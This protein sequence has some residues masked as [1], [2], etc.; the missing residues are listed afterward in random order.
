MKHALLFTGLLFALLFGQ[1]SAASC[2]ML[3]IETYDVD[4]WQG[5][6]K[7]V[8]FALHNHGNER[9][10]IDRVNAFDFESGLTVEEHS[11]DD[12]ALA[13]GEAMLR[14]EI[15][16][17]NNAEEGERDARIEVK[18]H[19]LGGKKCGFSDAG[20]GFSVSVLE[21][22]V[23]RLSPKC[24]GFALYT[25]KEK[26]IDGFGVIEFIAD[27]KTNYPAVITLEAPKMGLG[28]E[29]F[30]SKSGEEKIFSVEVQSAVEEAEL[31]YNVSLSSCGIPGEKTIV[32]SR[33]YPDP[34]PQP[35]PVPAEKE[36]EVNVSVKED[37][38]GFVAEVSIYNPGNAFVNGVLEASVASDWGVSG[39][40]YIEIEPYTE[41]IA[42]IRLV[43]P[44]GF[45]GKET[46]QIAFSWN[47]KTELKNFSMEAEEEK[48]LDVVGAAFAVLGSGAVLI[49]LLV[50][51]AILV[52]LL[53]SGPSRQ[54]FEP[55]LEKQAVK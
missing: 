22:P 55:W 31:V 2:G 45:S 32:Y 46:G 16:A 18:G 49:G 15:K 1:A 54:E 28:Q 7:V 40:G 39:D 37:T 8:S 5:E 11:S 30:Y 26:R 4:V 44:E 24:S 12:V 21:E 14:V 52:V 17:S 19:F 43:P 50:V 42:L 51:V 25:L 33:H 48:G 9:F 38:N 36:P 47:G 27:N 3:D 41:V 6:S 13:G 10:Y 20:K 29:V 35:T 23:H 34:A 53:F